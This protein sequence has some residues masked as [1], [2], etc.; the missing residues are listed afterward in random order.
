MNAQQSE[1]KLDPLDPKR[2]EIQPPIPTRPPD[3][4][5]KGEVDKVVGPDKPPG[6]L[7]D[8]P[9]VYTGAA[10]GPSIDQVGGP[11][12]GEPPENG[13]AGAGTPAAKRDR[14]IRAEDQ[15]DRTG[16]A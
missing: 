12:L 8:P 13:D 3:P 10:P 2:R 16:D 1:D 11:E 4:L 9:H 14:E 15:Q 6:D 7:T 5:A